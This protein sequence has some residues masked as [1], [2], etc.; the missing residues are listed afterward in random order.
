MPDPKQD[1][2]VQSRQRLLVAAAELFDQYGYQ[3][4]NVSDIAQRAGMTLGALYFHYG[5]K[6]GVAEAVMNAQPQVIEP[7]LESD[8]LQRVIDITLV[9]ADRLQVDPLLRAGVRLAVEQRGHGLS[10]PSS[11]DG[12]AAILTGHLQVAHDRGDL[13]PDVPPTAVAQFIVGACT[14]VQLYSQLVTDRADLMDRTCQMWRLLL[15]GIATD[16]ARA[17]TTIDPGRGRTA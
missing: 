4:A 8:G 6:Q 9:W 1:R 7:L 5:S 14:G 2:A 15:P 10:D 3:G 13:R 12:W 17:V 16:E 11:F